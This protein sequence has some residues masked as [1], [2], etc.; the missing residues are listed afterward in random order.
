[1]R[2]CT[3]CGNAIDD[4]AQSCPHCGAVQNGGNNDK[5]TV[6]AIPET[7]TNS[8][9]NVNKKTDGLSIAGFVI[10]IISLILCNSFIGPIIGLILSI[11]GTRRFD[12]SRNTSKWMGV[13]G[14]VLNAVAIAAFIIVVVIA[15]I[16]SEGEF[17]LNM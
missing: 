5:V 1:M 16:F 10:G 14:I 9:N 13:T 4:S 3:N 11:I 6:N 2:Y 17:V 8:I 7:N 12:P 15:V